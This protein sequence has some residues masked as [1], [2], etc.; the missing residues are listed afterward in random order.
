MERM[1][2]PRLAHFIDT[3][4][5][6]RPFQ[7]G[8]RRLH[9]TLDG[10][11]RL[12]SA[13]QDTFIRKEYMIAVFLDIEKAYDML[14]RYSIAQALRELGLVGHLP[15]FIMNFLNNRSIRVRIGDILSEAFLIENGIPQGS[16]LSCILF[17]IVIN[18]IF[19][20][21]V[22]IVKS[23]FC[24]DG[25]FWATGKT[26]KIARNKIRRA[27]ACLTDWSKKTGLKF[28]P[29]KTHYIIFTRRNVYRDPLL[30]LCGAPI[31]RKTRITYLGM[32]FDQKLT[33]RFHINE[34]VQR[35]E[36]N[37]NFTKSCSTLPVGRR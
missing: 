11:V 4:Q 23:L 20:E 8:F 31:E 15:K 36:K 13:I 7:S 24:D 19:D 16:V 35:C 17:L 2:L 33:W 10:L 32:I 29:S 14:W 28:S 21:T 34:I 6:I 18:S 30:I 12:E 1:V 5:Y 26:L 25:L 27:L 9:S 22:D 3:K 37:T